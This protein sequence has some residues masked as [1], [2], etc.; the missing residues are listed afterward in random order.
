MCDVIYSDDMIRLVVIAPK[1]ITLTTP[2]HL[3]DQIQSMHHTI[4]DNHLDDYIIWID[5]VDDTDT[6]KLWMSISDVGVLPSM[7]E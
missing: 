3:R 2:A 6:M 5:P 1:T 4:R 7:S